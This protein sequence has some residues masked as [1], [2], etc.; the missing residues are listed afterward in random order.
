MT[1]KSL[2]NLG[3]WL[4]SPT[5]GNMVANYLG[6]AW[7]G[8]L[9]L[10]L[11]PI[12]MKWLGPEQWGV[13]ALCLAAQ[14]VA[15]VID[16]G[17]SQVMPRDIARVNTDVPAQGR[18][19]KAFSLA[20]IILG[21]FGMGVGILA[22]PW[23][24]NSWFNGGQGLGEHA[25][26]AFV[27]ASLTFLFQFAN[28]ANIAYWNGL[29][30][31]G[32]ANIRTCSF[33]TA[34]HAL[35]LA[36]IIGGG[37]SAIGYLVPFALVSSLEFAVNRHGIKRS[38]DGFD[39]IQIGWVDLR[40]MVVEVR[41][42]SFSILVGM[43]VS[44]M[45]RVYLSRTLSPAQFGAYAALLSLGLAFMQLQYPV[46]LAI[47]PGAV[48]DRAMAGIRSGMLLVLGVC[49]VPC[50][51]VAMAAGPILRSW[52]GA[53]AIPDGG[54]LVF[55]MLLLAVALNALYHVVYQYMIAAGDGRFLAFVNVISLALST[56]I[57]MVF[58]DR[59]GIVVGGLSWVGISF[60]QLLL[61]MIWLMGKTVKNNKERL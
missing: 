11:L 5:G 2:A 51:L 59:L 56:M 40:K 16:L 34:K 8:V 17:L 57:L 9:N 36:V 15:N 41:G 54:I 23:L 20:Y 31:Q 26:I 44:Q 24:L 14:S 3:V 4:R 53:S 19:F 58:S 61:G 32:L 46:M 12:Y 50:A 1:L 30:R 7:V 6:V 29:Q 27:L 43:V 42:L 18:L 25:Q 35:A 21:G 13:V 28:G 52:M 38:I 10:A 47:F 22:S 45:D 48:R 39:R 49:V 33:A 55:Q 60:A 37:A